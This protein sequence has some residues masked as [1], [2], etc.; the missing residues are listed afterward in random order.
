MSIAIGEV[1]SVKGTNITVELYEESNNETLFYN[2]EKFNG[3]S[4]QE[5]ILIR[6]GFKDI[7]A[8]VQGEYLDERL[9]DEESGCYIRKVELVPIGHFQFNEFHEGIKHLPMIRDIAYLMSDTQVKSIFGKPDDNFV[10]GETLTEEIPISLPWVKLFNTH[11]GIFGNTGSGKS[12][13]LTNIYTTLFRNK[14]DKLINK[15]HFVVIDFNGEYT[16]NQLIS[17]DKYKKVYQLDTRNDDGDKFPLTSDVFWDEELFGI[18]F[19]ATENTQKPFLKRIV[20]G[21]NRFKDNP[22][23]L[24]KYVKSTIER[25]LTSTAQK[26]EFVALIEEIAKLVGSQDLEK[27]VREIGWHGERSRLYFPNTPHPNYFNGGDNDL[28]Y[29]HHCRAYVDDINIRELSPFNELKLRINTQLLSDLISGYVQFDHIQP[30]LKRVEASLTALDRVF[31]VREERPANMLLSVVSLRRTNQEIKKVMPLLLAKFYYGEHKQKVMNQSPPEQTFHMIIDEA[32]NILS[33]QSS[34]ESESWKDYR[35]ELFEEIIKEGRKFGFFLT[36]S[37]QRPADIS[38]TIMSQLHNFFIHRLVNERDLKLLENTISS[39]DE[40]SRQM[41]PNL[42]K[43]CSIIIGTSFD[44]PMVVQFNVMP[45]GS[46]P[47]SDDIDIE[48]LWN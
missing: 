1:I 32:H 31:D 16:N 45:D 14:L 20:S 48:S 17:K 21:R 27:K 15:S 38:P 29:N 10:V 2:G 42:S 23:S 33:T 22:D 24:Q 5:F 39:L 9:K 35:L 11:I 44:V 34:R 37:S 30:L 6:R 26:K 40:L 43:G 18:L 3:V 46:R 47:D 7:V 13:T 36:L 25:A 28:T 12:N 19:K 4:I 41:I 8:R